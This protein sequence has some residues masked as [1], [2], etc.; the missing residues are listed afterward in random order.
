MPYSLYLIKKKYY[1]Q[2]YIPKHQKRRK[3]KQPITPAVKLVHLPYRLVH[4]FNRF[5]A[6]LFAIRYCLFHCINGGLNSFKHFVKYLLLIRF[7]DRIGAVQDF[8]DLG[9]YFAFVLLLY[10]QK[11][12][13]LVG[14]LLK[15]AFGSV[16]KVG[17][18]PA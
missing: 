4:I 8:N 3:Q 5:I 7:N 14:H 1:P 13:L 10:V 2:H 9:A 11:L 12:H 18:S 17:Q 16:H 6:I 15:L